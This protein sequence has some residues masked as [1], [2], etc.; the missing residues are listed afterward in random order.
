MDLDITRDTV[1]YTFCDCDNNML[2]VK[3]VKKKKSYKHNNY[4]YSR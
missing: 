4:V 1:Y 3:N 2:L